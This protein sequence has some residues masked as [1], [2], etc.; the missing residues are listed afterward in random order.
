MDIIVLLV[1][2]HN[3]EVKSLANVPTDN[4]VSNGSS[5]IRYERLFS[6]M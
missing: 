3:I 6:M 4:R 5:S 1:P 2:L